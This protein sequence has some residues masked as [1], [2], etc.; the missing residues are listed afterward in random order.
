MYVVDLVADQHRE[1]HARAD[2][3]GRARPRRHRGRH[4]PRSL[5]RSP[6]A[7]LDKLAAV[8]IDYDDVVRTLEDEGVEKFEASWTDL[9]DAVQKELERKPEVDADE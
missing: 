4:H 6:S 3:A 2:P 8:G 9:I 5:R 1:H 7:S